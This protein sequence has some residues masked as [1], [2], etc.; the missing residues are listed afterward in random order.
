MKSEVLLTLKGFF[1]NLAKPTA[2]MDL[3]IKITV[4]A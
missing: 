2:A 4:N 1:V 3:T